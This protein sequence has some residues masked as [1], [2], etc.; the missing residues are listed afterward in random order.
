MCTRTRGE[1]LK[2]GSASSIAVEGPTDS[3]FL[4]PIDTA[5]NWRLGIVTFTCSDVAKIRVL[6]GD[7]WW[8]EVLLLLWEII[9]CQGCF[10]DGAHSYCEPNVSDHFLRVIVHTC[11]WITGR[12][13]ERDQR[14]KDRLQAHHHEELES[15]EHPSIRA[16][17]ILPTKKCE[18]LSSQQN[19]WAK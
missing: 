10:V 4:K 2:I 16:I 6:I 18:S 15:G 1:C 13:E 17:Q 3:T 19:H 12:R 7:Q 9:H 8:P 14:S 5:R 11:P